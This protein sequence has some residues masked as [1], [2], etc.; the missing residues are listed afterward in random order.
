[1]QLKPMSV[2]KLKIG[3]SIHDMHY[4]FPEWEK[5]FNLEAP[6]EVSHIDMTIADGHL[7][8]QE[9][10][11]IQAKTRPTECNETTLKSAA[12]GRPYPYTNKILVFLGTHDRR[13]LALKFAYSYD[14][15]RLGFVSLT[16]VHPKTPG[17]GT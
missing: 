9:I 1:M 15:T 11:K 13:D 6:P 16:D 4:G 14:G 17:E 2:Y 3:D 12:N 7:V 5:L 10:L 8:I